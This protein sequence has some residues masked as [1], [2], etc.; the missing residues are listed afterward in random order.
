MVT[1]IFETGENGFR[2]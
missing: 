1:K 2:Y